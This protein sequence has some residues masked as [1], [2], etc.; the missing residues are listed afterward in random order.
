MFADFLPTK[1]FHNRWFCLS[2]ST[3]LTIKIL[4]FFVKTKKTNVNVR[5]K[6]RKLKLSK[7]SVKLSAKPSNEI[8]PDNPIPSLYLSF[9]PIRLHSSSFSRAPPPLCGRALAS[10]E[11]AC[12]LLPLRSTGRRE[13]GQPSGPPSS[14][15]SSTPSPSPI[16]ATPLF[17]SMVG[18]RGGGELP[19]H[20]LPW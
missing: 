5:L 19:K 9:D 16:P 8:F 18:R 14:P 6:V 2:S 7:I 10:R 1:L 11:G 13:P 17:V 20:P 4:N 12:S 3:M 15:P